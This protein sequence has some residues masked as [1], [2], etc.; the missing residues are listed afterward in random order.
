MSEQELFIEARQTLPVSGLS[1]LGR[2]S[3][4]VETG[5]KMISVRSINCIVKGRVIESGSKISNEPL[6]EHQ[7]RRVDD[8]KSVLEKMKKAGLAVFSVNAD[9][10]VNLNQVRSIVPE[11]E[12]AQIVFCD[13]QSLNTEMPFERARSKFVATTTQSKAVPT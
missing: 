1:W 5:S 9:T 4:R 10:Y 13:G 12:R 8:D 2:F 11:R 7:A 6:H 3:P